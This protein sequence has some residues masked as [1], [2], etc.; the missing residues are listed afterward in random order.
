[1]ENSLQ[2]GL[3]NNRLYLGNVRVSNGH[4]FV[5]Q[6]DD[7]LDIYYIFPSGDLEYK[8]TINATLLYGDQ[9][10]IYITDCAIGG[11]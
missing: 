10:K 1:M 9:S 8:A 5:P 3:Q 4:L 2:G 7:G 6:G 11:E